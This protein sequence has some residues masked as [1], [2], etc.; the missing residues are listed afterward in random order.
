MAASKEKENENDNDSKS[1]SDSAI[2]S[3]IERRGKELA[4]IALSNDPSRLDNEIE[5]LTPEEAVV[6][7]RLIEAS[8]KKRRILIAGYLAALLFMVGGMLTAFYV[9]SQR[10]PGE[11]LGWVFLIPFGLVAASL[12]LF[13]RW[14]RSQ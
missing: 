6:F 7:L 14:A 8:L 2:E 13:G 5:H 3:A 10:E 11:F 12:I 9:Y 1:D 4:E